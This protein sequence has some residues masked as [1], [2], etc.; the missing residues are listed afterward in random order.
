MVVP[1]TEMGKNREE[2]SWVGGK[3]G[4]IKRLI[5]FEHTPFDISMR[6]S[7]EDDE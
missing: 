6:Q 2:V 1:L 7:S 4:I 3:Q 5:S